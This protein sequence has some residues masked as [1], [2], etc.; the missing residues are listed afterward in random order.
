MHSCSPSYAPR[1]S[2]WTGTTAGG[3]G[4]KLNRH[5]L[6]KGGLY[7]CTSPTSKGVYRHPRLCGGSVLQEKHIILT[8][9]K[10]KEIP[11]RLSAYKSLH[12]VTLAERVSGQCQ[13]LQLHN[14]VTSAGRKYSSYKLPRSYDQHLHN[15]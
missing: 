6:H 11:T 8:Y 3:N 12:Y 15:N 2:H 10:G 13:T 5:V 7:T 14:H 4:T 1:E 9:L